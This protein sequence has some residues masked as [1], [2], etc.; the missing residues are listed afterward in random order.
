MILVDANLL[1]YARDE[2]SEHHE[3][4]RSWL[5][6]QLNG[7]N[8]VGLP[9]QS[10]T[11]F[12][13][14]ATHPRVYAQPLTPSEAWAQIEDWLA[15]GPSW[16]PVPT[17]RHAAVLRSLVADHHVAG[18]L[19]PDAVLAALAVEHGLEVCSA[20]TDFAAFTGLSWHNPLRD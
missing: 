12:W 2:S 20:D 10:L 14:I 7:T 16:V 19:V 5:T 4:A 11:A 9:W 1:L 17:Q 8:R 15:A 18:N 6:T 3:K 13:R